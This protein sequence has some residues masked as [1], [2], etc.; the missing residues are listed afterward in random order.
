ARR[1]ARKA[2]LLLAGLD[3]FPASRHRDALCSLIDYVH[4]RTR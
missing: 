4:G 1:Q 3:W 2:A